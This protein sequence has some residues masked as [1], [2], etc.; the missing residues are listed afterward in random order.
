MFKRRPLELFFEIFARLFGKSLLQ[1]RCVCKSWNALISS[2]SFL[3]A[4]LDWNARK[5]ACDYL[6]ISTSNAKCLSLLCAETYVKCFDFE[7]PRDVISSGFSV[8]GSS[9]GLVTYLILPKCLVCCTQFAL[10]TLGFGFDIGENDYKVVTMRSG[11]GR[12]VSLKLRFT[13]LVPLVSHHAYLQDKCACLNEDFSP[14]FYWIL[15]FDLRS[16][17]FQMVMLPDRLVNTINMTSNAISIQVFEKSLSLFHLR[18]DAKDRYCNIFVVERDTW[19]LIRTILLPESREIAW[20]LGITT[21]DKVHH[22][23]RIENL[24]SRELVLYD[25]ES[26]QIKETGIK[27][28]FYGLSRYINAYWES[29][30]LLS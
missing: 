21:K 25:P 29:L 2:P 14:G 26:Q 12:R 11:C 7:L 20:L 1:L 30:V 18:Q 19:K 27:L 24:Q 16:E 22:A 13:A 9:N 15:S 10:T 23:A 28:S 3:N 5:S 17:S 8:F 4:H 6:L